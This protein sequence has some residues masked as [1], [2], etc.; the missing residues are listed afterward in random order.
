M[1][2][3]HSVTNMKF[4]Y[5][6]IS[7]YIRIEK[8]NTNEY[9]NIFVSKKQYERI[10]EYIRIKKMIRTNIRIYSY[11]KNDTNMIRTNIPNRK[12]SNIQI[13]LYQIIV[14]TNI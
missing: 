10:S 9:P 5:E 3:C 11:K 13:Y 4:R 6:R 1:N 2:P 8:N 12:Y 14:P 7:E